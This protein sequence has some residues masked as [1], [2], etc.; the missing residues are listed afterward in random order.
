VSVVLLANVDCAKCGVAYDGLWQVDAADD[1]QDL[2]GAP[3]EEMTC[4]ACG[5]RQQETWPGWTSYTEAGL[6]T[7][8]G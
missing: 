7:K 4:P 3:V 2:D 5:H 1:M 6:A 8:V